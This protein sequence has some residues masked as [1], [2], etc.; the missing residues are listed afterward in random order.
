[1]VVNYFTLVGEFDLLRRLLGGTVFVPRHV[2]D[3]DEDENVGDEIA[4][5]LRRGLRL[6]RRW[7]GEEPG[8]QRYQRAMRGLASLERILVHARDGRLVAVDLAPAEF[9]LYS[10]LRDDLIAARFGLSSGLG[11]GEA[12]ALAI[13][14]TRDVAIATDD[15]AAISV[16]G[17]MSATLKVHRI[18]GLLVD[19]ID[20]GLISRSEG[21]QIHTT[22]KWAGFWDRGVIQ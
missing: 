6:Y 19:A 3:P 11:R 21:Q 18:R 1:M 8:S 5:E 4:S 10:Q 2:F 17:G 22:M 9:A 16:G 7:A 20:R 14:L 12:A 15:E 13:A